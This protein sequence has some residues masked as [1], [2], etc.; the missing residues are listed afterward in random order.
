MDSRPGLDFAAARERMVAGQIE[1][2]GFCDP[3]LLRA[4]RS[5][6]REDFVPEDRRE[7]AYEDGPLEIGEGQTISQPLIVAYMIALA[8]L[9]GGETVLE[10]GAGS[11]Y[12]AAVL[13]CIAA[14]V[15]AIERL[16]GLA[17]AAAARLA[18]MSA[19][20]VEIICG[21]GTLGLKERAPFDAIIVSAAAPAA[22]P[23]LKHQLKLG[24]RLIVPVGEHAQTLTRITRVSEDGF[25]ETA[26][27]PVMFVPL[28][29]AEGFSG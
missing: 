10:V 22:P 20:N 12:A 27:A 21:D 15:F 25:E 2:R 23:T 18:A 26:L 24:G 3:I 1:A 19:A 8:K 4:L 29:G 16:R 7:R 9:R 14:R 17:S 11:G 5:V 13:G 6:R 28:I